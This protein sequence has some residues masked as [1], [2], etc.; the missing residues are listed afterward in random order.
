MN[1]AARLRPTTLDAYVGQEHLVGKKGIIRKMIESGNIS[2][3]IFW[4]PPG[5]GKTTLAQIVATT[6]N[7]SFHQLS[8]VSSGKKDLEEIIRFAQNDS[9]EE[10]RTILFIDEIHRWNKA[11]QDALL[12]YVESGLIIL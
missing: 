8:G 9:K 7:A 5:T 6:T 3:M 10:K 1:L 11:Q 2:S 12:P 4:G